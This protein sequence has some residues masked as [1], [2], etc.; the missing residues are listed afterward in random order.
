[1]SFLKKLSGFGNP[2]SGIRR[3]IGSCVLIIGLIMC[4]PSIAGYFLANSIYES[5]NVYDQEKAIYPF[6][7]N[8]S[9]TFDE[10]DGIMTAGNNYDVRITLEAVGPASDIKD[11]SISVFSECN[12]LS[13]SRT[14]QLVNFNGTMSTSYKNEMQQDRTTNVD[15]VF[16]IT[17]LTFNNVTSASIR[18][19]IYENPNRPLISTINSIAT[20]LLIPGLI[21]ICCGC[22]IAPPKKKQ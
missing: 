13:F 8:A 4:I 10:I 7:I 22:C 6:A 14:I 18:L 12:E 3:T 15:P 11:G 1:M 19:R 17:V 9:I 5:S 21:V 16:N 2:I 20:I